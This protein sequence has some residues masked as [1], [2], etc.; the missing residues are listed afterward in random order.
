MTKN[1]ATVIRDFNTRLPNTTQKFYNFTLTFRRGKG[2]AEGKGKVKGN[3]KGKR[4]VRREGNGEIVLVH[5]ME[6]YRGVE[7]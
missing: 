1:C 5:A 6:T 2:N 4:K 7:V 3:C